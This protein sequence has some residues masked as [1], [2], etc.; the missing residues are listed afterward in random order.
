MSNVGEKIRI[1]RE[2]R[3]MTQQE[4]AEQ[5]GYENHSPLGLIERGKRPAKPDLVKKIADILNYPVEWFYTENE[6]D[7][8]EK[9]PLKKLFNLIPIVS[10]VDLKKCTK[11]PYCTIDWLKK[12]S[13]KG[14]NT[15]LSREKVSDLSFSLEVI[16]ESMTTNFGVSFPI[17]A[18]ILIDPEVVASSGDFVIAALESTGE[19]VFNQYIIS[20]GRKYLRPL[21]PQFQAVEITDKT[22][23]LGVVVSM[24]FNFKKTQ[25]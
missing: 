2:S 3:E 23:I 18:I 24:Y 9:Y 22:V 17:G 20:G 10:W 16:D 11:K 15:I 19:P 21:S 12:V 8:P 25:K 1:A 13:S 7:D 4:L 5:V 14:I 6:I